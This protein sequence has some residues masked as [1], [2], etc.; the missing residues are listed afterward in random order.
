M[1]FFSL[2]DSSYHLLRMKTGNEILYNK[3]EHRPYGVIISVGKVDYYVPMKHDLNVTSKP[4]LDTAVYL[5]PSQTLN[6]P[7]G[8]FDFQ[9]V[10]PIKD[11]AYSFTLNNQ[12]VANDQRTLATNMQNQIASKLEKYVENYKYY[13]RGENLELVDGPYLQFRII[14]KKIWWNYRMN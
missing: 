6:Y 14:T 10:L 11:D 5:I 7:Y 13:Q 8:G 12:L 2:D 4:F 9:H 3:S 1:N